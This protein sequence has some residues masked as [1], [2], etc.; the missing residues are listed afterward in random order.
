MGPG[1]TSGFKIH[2]HSRH[3]GEFGPGWIGH[4]DVHDGSRTRELRAIL[5]DNSFFFF[6]SI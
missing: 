3:S 1:V 2:V 5:N 6:F 4:Y